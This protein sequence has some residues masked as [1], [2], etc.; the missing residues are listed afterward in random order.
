M[1]ISAQHI[2]TIAWAVE[3]FVTGNEIFIVS[4]C[5]QLVWYVKENLPS[6]TGLCEGHYC[7]SR[8]LAKGFQPFQPHEYLIMSVCIVLYYMNNPPIQLRLL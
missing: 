1:D 3:M 2:D 8:V 6:Q 4:L 7:A 5:F